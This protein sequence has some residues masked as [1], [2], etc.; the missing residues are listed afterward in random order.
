MYSNVLNH[1][2]RCSVLV[3]TLILLW[4]LTLF[5]QVAEPLRMLSHRLNIN[6]CTVTMYPQ[7][8]PITFHHKISIEFRHLAALVQLV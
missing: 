1:V 5:A 4:C 8:T 3:C 2:F 7:S 6:P